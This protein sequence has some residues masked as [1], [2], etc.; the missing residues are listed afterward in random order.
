M[1]SVVNAGHTVIQP[2][3]L[4]LDVSPSM[5][6][7]N[8]PAFR[9]PIQ[10]L[11]D[12]IRTFVTDLSNVT[13]CG[14][15]VMVITFDESVQ[16]E[17]DFEA[18]QSLKVPH[19]AARGGGTNLGGAIG[20]A[21]DEVQARKDYMKQTG[22]EVNQPWLVCVTDGQPNVNTCPGFDARLIDLVNRKKCLFLPVAVGGYASYD[23]L[24]RLSP[25]QK[26]IVVGS[27]QAGSMSFKDFFAYLSRS[28]AS[29]QMP[30]MSLLQ[31]NHE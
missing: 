21:L 29:G 20:R 14:V 23:T 4:V 3:V 25:L 9:A 18:V 8:D 17:C 12:A 16:V 22:L 15:E 6:Q 28:A 24:E 11:N 19:C 10:D 30:N 2:I 31:Q 13:H 27:S 26:P 7:A 5:A 1:T